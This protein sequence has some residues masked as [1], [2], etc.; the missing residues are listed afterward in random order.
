M[1]SNGDFGK[2]P[3]RVSNGDLLV[4]ECIAWDA[5][6]NNLRVDVQLF[7][8]PLLFDHLFVGEKQCSF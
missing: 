6:Y 1:K 2:Y 8:L 4:E 5:Y 3:K 7:Y